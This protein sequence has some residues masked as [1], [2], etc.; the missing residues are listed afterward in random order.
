MVPT[1]VVGTPRLLPSDGGPAHIAVKLRKKTTLFPGAWL[2]GP[3]YGRV[4]GS[5]VDSKVP[6]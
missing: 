2:L 1:R 4:L 6:F 5:V 3:E